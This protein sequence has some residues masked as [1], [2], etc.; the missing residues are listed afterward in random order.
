MPLRHLR[1]LVLAALAAATLLPASTAAAADGA[2]VATDKMAAAEA[3]LLR[4]INEIRAMNGRTPLR[5]DKRTSHVARSRSLDMA[6]KRYFAHTEP[7]GDEAED[8]LDRRDI[9]AREVTENIGH[10]VGLTLKAGSSR[11]ADWWYHSPPHRVQMLAKDVNYVGVGIARHGSRFTYT[12]IF[13][14]SPDKTSPRVVIDAKRWHSDADGS[15]IVLDW[16]GVDP[17]LAT[18][19]AGLKRFEV[20]HLNSLGHWTRIEADPQ[21]SKLRLR[22]LGSG[23]QHLRV[24][25]IDKAGNRGPWKYAHLDLPDSLPSRVMDAT[26]PRILSLDAGLA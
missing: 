25:A 19:T 26:P 1:Y 14:R 12:A 20:Q 17:K 8:I 9:E 7:D 24:R 13:T 3:R 6:A 5:L 22:I 11:M 10:T 15:E 21:K 16:H 18:G 23:D 2:V 4:E